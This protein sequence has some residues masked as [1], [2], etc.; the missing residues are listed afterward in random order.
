MIGSENKTIFYFSKITVTNNNIL[1]VQNSLVNI[2][3]KMDRSM[4]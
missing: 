1:K 2:F 4:L 3:E